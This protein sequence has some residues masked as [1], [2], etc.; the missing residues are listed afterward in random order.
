MKTPY[1]DKTVEKFTV[2]AARKCDFIFLGT[3]LVIAREG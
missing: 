2:E 1:G 3:S